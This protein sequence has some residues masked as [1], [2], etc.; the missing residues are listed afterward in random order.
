MKNK[1][2]GKN[3]INSSIQIRWNK[4]IKKYFFKNDPI[5]F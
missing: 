1:K 4:R 3:R 5:K 2:I